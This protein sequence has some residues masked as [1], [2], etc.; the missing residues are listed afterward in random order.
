MREEGT[1]GE[2]Q[3]KQQIAEAVPELQI[4]K[5]LDTEC[6]VHMFDQFKELKV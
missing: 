2:S 5:L 3:N 1:M 6:R 4:K